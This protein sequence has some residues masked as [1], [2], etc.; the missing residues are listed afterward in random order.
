MLAIQ[1]EPTPL[2]TDPDGVVRVGGTRVT[3][4]TL[5]AAFADGLTPEEIVYE[6]PSLPL[7]EVYVVLGYYLRHRA[8]VETYLHQRLDQ[9]EAVRRQNEARFDPLGIRARLLAR[10][11]RTY[12]V[13]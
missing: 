2:A 5:V 3:L 8:E 12:A 7:A 4:D 6:Y 13:D 10:Q 1:T 9:A 11:T